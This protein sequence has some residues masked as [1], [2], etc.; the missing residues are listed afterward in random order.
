[1][2]KFLATLLTIALALT[3]VFAATTET[4][5]L[6][7]ETDIAPVNQIMLIAVEHVS[8]AV[9]SGVA[10]TLPAE[11]SSISFLHIA[12]LQFITNNAGQ[13][14]V[15]MSGTQ[16]TSTE[17]NVIPYTLTY[18]KDGANA[19]ITPDGGQAGQAPNA[20]TL[21]NTPSVAN[22]MTV[23]KDLSLTIGDGSTS[24]ANYPAG[25]YEATITFTIAAL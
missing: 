6:K 15:S 25:S 14:T 10:Y 2:K 19:S 17:G 9:V 3:G 20:V 22:L 16:F 12:D 4:A 5:T 21:F 18:D 13:V 8:E 1:M 23:T 7:L 24:Y 11:F